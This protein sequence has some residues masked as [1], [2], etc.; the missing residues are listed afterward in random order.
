M[1]SRLALLILLVIIITVGFL[2]WW[3]KGQQAPNPSD[4]SSK[5]FVVKKGTSIRELGN[6]LKKEGLISD[7]VVFFL[8][9]KKNHLDT[10]IQAGDF[11]LSPNMKLSTIV[12]QLQHGS[13]DVWVTVPEGLRADEIA[14]ILQAKMPNYNES[15]RETLRANE[16]YLFHET[17]LLPRDGDIDSIVSIMRKTFFDRVADLG[18]TEDSANL[19]RIVT[20]AS[21]IERESRHDDEKK[22]VASIIYNRLEIGMPLQ[23]DATLQYVKG[24]SKAG[25]WWSVPTGNDRKIDSPYNTYQ[26]LGLPPGPI[27]NPGYGS[28][29]AAV[30]PGKSNY[31][32]YIHDEHGTIHYAKTVEEHNRN[33]SQYLN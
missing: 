28:L 8:Y 14:D 26:N 18:L 12:D 21:L 27:A 31:L 29:A 16:G 33:V 23:I 5:V 19:N 25:K 4:S 7:P 15:W 11:K 9:I 10:K 32:Y 3:N 13:L 6:S 22:I 24:K 17:Y 2:F 1:R 20:I 30:N